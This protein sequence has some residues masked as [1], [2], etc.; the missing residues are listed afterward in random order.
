MNKAIVV[1]VK[2]VKESFVHLVLNGGVLAIADIAL[3]AVGS[4]PA[5]GDEVD[6]CILDLTHKGSGQL[7]VS[8]NPHLTDKSSSESHKTP[9]K[10]IK[11]ALLQQVQSQN[12]LTAL[13]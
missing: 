10:K 13:C 9:S 5:K 1:Q 3:L 6:C 11:K 7:M 8:L 4:I 12:Q 2:S